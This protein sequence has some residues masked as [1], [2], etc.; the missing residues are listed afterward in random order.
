[1]PVARKEREN[2]PYRFSQD[3]IFKKIEFQKNSRVDREKMKVKN[4]VENRLK[5][6]GKSRQNWGC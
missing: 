1:M 5:M 6:M 2:H 4:G 3:F